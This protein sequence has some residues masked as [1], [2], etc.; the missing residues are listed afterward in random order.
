MT[1]PSSDT[2]ALTTEAIEERLDYFVDMVLSS[3]RTAHEPAVNL[4]PHSRQEQ[5]FILAKIE[6]I[7]STNAELAYQFICYAPA[8]LKIMD[9]K[10]ID[11]WLYHTM[12]VF[13]KTGLHGAINVLQDVHEIGRAHV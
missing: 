3:R 1:S 12:D 11:A 9:F 5:E 8:A 2:Q 4:S 10:G 7:A 6:I 13:D